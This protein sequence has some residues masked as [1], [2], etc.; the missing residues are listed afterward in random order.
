MEIEFAN[1]LLQVKPSPTLAVSEKAAQLKNEGRDIIGLGTGEPDFDTPINIKKAAI[2]AIEDGFTKY[3]AVDGILELKQAIQAK[4]KRDNNIEYET[5]QILVSVGGKQSCFNL[6]LACLNPGDEVIIPA[7]YWVSYPDMVLLAE[8]TPV[9]LSTTPE[10][11]YKITPAQLD[12]AITPKTKLIF[13]NSPSN[14]SGV[15]YTEEELYALSQVLLRHPHVLIASDDMYEHILWSHKFTNILMVCP[16]LY[17]RTILL[18]G[19]SKAYA[20]TGWRIGYAA[21]PKPLMKAMKKIQSQSTSNPC[22]I[23]Q[24]AAVEALNGP[25]DSIK[26][27]LDSFKERHDY[28]CNR[29]EAMPGVHVVPANGTF[30]IFPSVNEII[31]RMGLKNDIE[32]AAKL[33]EEEGLALVPGSAFGTEGCIRISFAA[34]QK[35]LEKAMDRLE[36][37]IT[38]Q[39]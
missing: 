20:M 9:I 19:V 36:R 37:F 5:S 14:P 21:G 34:S 10:T 26:I 33:L 32:F 18:N 24:K 6:C 25:Q 11:S 29:L 15:A 28:V 39:K 7:P 1:R 17:E 27:M 22:S 38:K 35:N 3:T 13:L 16:E 31:T 4:F 8:G 23:A 30:Y 12:K 2:K